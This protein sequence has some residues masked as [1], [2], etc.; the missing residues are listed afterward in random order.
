[1]TSSTPDYTVH[2]KPGCPNCVKTMEYFD[3]KGITY[4]AVDITKVPEALT[5]ICEDLGYSEAPVVV[6]ADGTDHW[7]GIRMDKLTQ[8]ALR[9]KAA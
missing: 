4:Q 5:Y 2:T 6:S 7:S 3:R 8:A 1:M 9:R